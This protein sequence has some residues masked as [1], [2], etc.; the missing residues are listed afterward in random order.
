M[1][2][3]VAARLIQAIGGALAAVVAN[4]T[5]R[6]KASGHAATQ[7]FAVLMTVTA[8]APIIAPAI[9][10]WLDAALGWRS[11]FW[12]LAALGA[13]TLLYALVCLKESHPAERRKPLALG[14]TM[15]GYGA[16]RSSRGF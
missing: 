4:S 9:G 2:W 3:L 10:G 5:V 11:V 12:V 1:S 15:R 13:L 7:L 8:V 6:D 16:L 14:A